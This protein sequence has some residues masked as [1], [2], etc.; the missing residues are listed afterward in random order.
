[1]RLTLVAAGFLLTLRPEVAQSAI[2]YILRGKL[3]AGR[4]TWL[5]EAIGTHVP[6]GALKDDLAGE[7]TNLAESHWLSVR[8]LAGRLLV[9]HGRPVPDLPA[10]EPAPQ[11]SA[12]FHALL[13]PSDEDDE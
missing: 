3:D 6:A 13:T 5:L 4:T 9:K 1:M 2:A 10:T 11:I 12:G 8:H 7:L